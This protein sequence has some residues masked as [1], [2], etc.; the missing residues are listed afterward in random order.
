[1]FSQPT[2]QFSPFFAANR[3]Q[4]HLYTPVTPSPLRTSRNANLMPTSPERKGGGS[5]PLRFGSSPLGK[6]AAADEQDENSTSN[7]LSGFYLQKTPEA[8]KQYASTTVGAGVL[9]TPPDSSS[10]GN[11][12]AGFGFQR[13]E[14]TS[15][16]PSLAGSAS[17]KRSNTDTWESRAK[18][19]GSA[20]T[21]ARHAAQGRE[22]KKSRFLDRIRRRR[23][24]TRSEL[25]GDQVL[26]MDFVRERRIWEDE[27]RRRAAEAGGDGTEEVDIDMM[28]DEEAPED[29]MSPTEEFDPELESYYDYQTGDML[30][31]GGP[32]EGLGGQNDD[33]FLVDE[34]EEYEEVFREL[35]FKDEFQRSQGKTLQYEGGGGDANASGGQLEHEAG[36]DLS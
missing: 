30:D 8:S 31:L 9:A 19:L 3:P 32:R 1:M 15:A 13:T 20:N 5:S 34:D 18:S 2:P 14:S 11:G 12:Q 4:P 10:I 21:L 22:Q 33:N 36:M 27:M 17:G 23:D 25:V 35:I 7:R 6:F 26:R 28:L 24:D 29:E 16:F